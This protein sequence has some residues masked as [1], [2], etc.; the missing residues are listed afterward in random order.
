MS[1]FEL[2]FPLFSFNLLTGLFDKNWLI[3][4]SENLLLSWLWPL[5]AV[6]EKKEGYL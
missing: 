1:I 3:L 4:P 5:A 2:I 6:G